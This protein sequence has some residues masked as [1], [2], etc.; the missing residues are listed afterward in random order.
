MTEQ[1]Q[2]NRVYRVDKVAIIYEMGISNEY[3]SAAK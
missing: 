3:R 2:E 1:T